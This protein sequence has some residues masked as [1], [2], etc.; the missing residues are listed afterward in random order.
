MTYRA[1][2]SHRASILRE[3]T[4]ENAT[5]NLVPTTIVSRVV[6][7]TIV[8]TRVDIVRA[9]T[10]TTDTIREAI[11]LVNN[12]NRLRLRR[13]PKALHPPKALR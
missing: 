6:T 2:I 5:I 9:T 10:T 7:A 3:I 8:T 4:S 11:S 13:A 12:I 1:T